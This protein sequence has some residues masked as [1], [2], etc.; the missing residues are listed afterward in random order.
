MNIY[1]V[2]KE[3]PNGFHDAIVLDVSPPAGGR[4]LVL[5][6]DIWVSLLD[7]TDPDRYRACEIRFAVESSVSTDPPGLQVQIGQMLDLVESEEALNA[8]RF[9]LYEQKALLLIEP[10]DVTWEWSAPHEQ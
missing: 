5:K 6:L 4:G 7:D 8:A 2:E 1:E 3:L 9:F 10:P